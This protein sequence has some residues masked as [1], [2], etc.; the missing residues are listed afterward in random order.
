[1]RKGIVVLLGALLLA[2]LPASIGA[3]EK[4]D[5]SASDSGWYWLV[6]LSLPPLADG[7]SAA[8][9][10][11]EKQAFRAAAQ[12]A[13]VQYKER[14]AF[15]N[16]WNGLSIEIN[17]VDLARVTRLPG[18]KAV[19]PNVTMALPEPSSEDPQLF[20][21]LAITG[22]NTAQNVLGLTGTGVN[23]GVI[24]TGVD[25]HHPDLGGCFGMGCRVFT[26]Y[27]FVGDAFN[28]S[29]TG[30]ALIPVPDPDPDD[31]NG[32]GTH[33]SG[34]VGANGNVTGVAPGVRFGA[35]RVFG[36]TGTTRA[37]IMIAAM[38]RALAD[39]MH[40]VNMSIGAAR[41]WPQYPTATAGTRLVNKGV[42][43]VASAGNDSGQGI[44]ASSAPSV[45]QKVISVASV[46]NSH[47]FS[48]AFQLASGTLV[49][50]QPMT[51]SPSFPTT[52][53][54]GIEQVTAGFPAAAAC[55]A[56]PAGSLTGKVALIRRGTCSFAIKATNAR[57]AGA[58]FVLI[59]N[60]APGIFL[61][62]L[63]APLSPP[64]PVASI[65]MEDGN[66]IVGQLPTSLT[67]TNQSTSAPLG[68]AGLISSF[69]SYG[70]SPNL[71]VKP[72]IS[73]PGGFIYSTLPL[74]LGGYGVNSGTSMSS[75]HTAGGVA[76]LLEA[77][78]NMPSQAVGRILQNSADPKLWSGNPG[79]G[80]LDLV[81][82]Q[83]AGT[84]DIPGA[85]LATT[86]IEPGK[87]SL[88]ESE[89]GPVTRTLTIENKGM[90]DVTYDLSHVP[91]LATGPS[92]FPPVSF[93]N[94]PATV[95]FSA[96]T[97]TVPAGGWASVDVTISPNPGLA[98]RS[99][100]GG[101]I[102]FTPQG[103]G[104]VYRVPFA[105]FK[106]DYQGFPVLTSAGSGFPWLAKL[107]G[108]TFFNQP[109]GATYTLAGGDIPYILFHLDHQV[110]YLRME[111]V[112]AVSG[113]SWHRALHADYVARNSAATSFF[114]QPWDGTTSA[115]N[116]VYTVPD[117]QYRIILTVLK[118]LGDPNNPAHIET[119]TSPVI[120][121]DRP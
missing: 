47:L 43:V 27:D 70:V 60:N 42:V 63:G 29:G 86:R 116:K 109:S 57:N 31:C 2:A 56:L 92:T 28:S 32:H 35:Y 37:D 102:V 76:L 24:D 103:G 52:G 100:Y 104:Q 41:Q 101:Y 96:P 114:A 115:G 58:S 46:D 61:G 48:P 18:V 73:A 5:V 12:S 112:D 45:G 62:T 94:A 6:E 118:A 83:G 25:Y 8:A 74:E 55:S 22:A 34:I 89:F 97:V 67:W 39:G 106:G 33:V 40:V 36:C 4:V 85:V 68:T 93:F 16:L 95:A 72:D 21:A 11:S 9:L 113:K 88:G 87:L 111:V 90:A 99:L 77:H 20:T 19:Y 17:P 84:L 7:G 82:R 30:S 3:Q 44:Y 105:G 80:F 71:D 75:P 65:S 26:G 117:G 78:P 119:W 110:R 38:E 81:H 54:Y 91:A 64:I 79:L 107:V 49:G 66:L 120:T 69:S 1:M 59:Y 51:F 50:Y 10:K 53:T 121:I 15:D 14:Y 23:V 108:T 98:D 13:G